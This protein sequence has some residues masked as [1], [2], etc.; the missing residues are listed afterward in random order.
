MVGQGGDP[1]CPRV[2]EKHVILGHRYGL[3][4]TESVPRDTIESERLF[5]PTLLEVLSL[6]RGVERLTLSLRTNN[7]LDCLSINFWIAYR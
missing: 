5:F 6:Q 7:T 1:P 2:S 4:I 3:F